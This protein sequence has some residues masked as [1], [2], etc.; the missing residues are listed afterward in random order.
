MCF[1]FRNWA[2]SVFRA[3][4]AITGPSRRQRPR[5]LRSAS[6]VRSVSAP[7]GRKE[8]S[9]VAGKGGPYSNAT[10]FGGSKVVT[11]HGIRISL[12]RFLLSLGRRRV[13]MER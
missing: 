11:V 7:L 4:R 2:A 6:Q 12:A 8:K 9:L 10:R 1:S 5:G 3:S 13:E